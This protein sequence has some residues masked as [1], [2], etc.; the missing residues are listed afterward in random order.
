MNYISFPGLGINEFPLKKIAFSLFGRDVAWYGIII[1]CGIILALLYVCY[2]A[3]KDE[4][5]KIDDVFDYAIYLVFFGVLGARL[6]YV[7][8]EFD[9]YKGET[10]GQTFMNVIAIWEGGLAIYGGIIAGAIALVCVSYYKRIKTAKAFD[11]VAPAVMIGQLI[12]RWGNFFNAEAHGG[13]TA[14]PWR[15]GIRSPEEAT[16]TFYHPTFLYESLWNLVGFILINLFY[17]KKRYDGQIFIMYITWYGFGR[18]LIEGLR[19]DSLYVGGFRISQVIAFLC[20][21]FG[22]AFLTAMEIVH[23]LRKRDERRA[24][25]LENGEDEAIE[26]ATEGVTEEVTEEVTKE[27]TE[28]ITESTDTA[29]VVEVEEETEAEATDEAEVETDEVADELEDEEN[30][31]ELNDAESVAELE[32]LDGATDTEAEASDEAETEQNETVSEEAEDGNEE[33]FEISD[34]YADDDDD[35]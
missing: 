8:M 30:L 13:E 25:A 15:M 14:L 1:T 32:A 35:E 7:I 6:Y 2:R 27:I 11:M 18:M 26:E 5:I 31:T 10:F 33:M 28:E 12:G 29:G 22:A 24:L 16:A 17:R 23:Q 21:F 34:S 3:K 9:S 4:G 19:T 20:F